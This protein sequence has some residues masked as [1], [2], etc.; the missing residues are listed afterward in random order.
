[1][2]DDKKMSKSIKIKS[3]MKSKKLL[4]YLINNVM[5]TSYNDHQICK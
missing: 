1:M 2:V 3:H 5:K 4:S